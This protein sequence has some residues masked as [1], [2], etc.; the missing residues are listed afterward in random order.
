[1]TTYNINAKNINVTFNTKYGKVYGVKDVSINFLENE[2]TGIIGESGSGKSLLG[3]SILKLLSNEA[4]VT[5]E[6]YFANKD[7]ISLNK[8]QIKGIR[9]CKVGFIPQNPDLSLNPLLTI[10]RQLR[11]PLMTHLNMKKDESI[12]ICKDY[13]KKFGFEN[14][15]KIIKSYPF[16]L[17]GG[18][19]QRILSIIGIICNPK[20]LIADEPTKGLDSKLRKLV[21]ENLLNIKENYIPSMIVITHDL[22]F[23]A[24]LCDK[25][26]VM[27]KGQIVEMGSNFD[28]INNPKHPYTIGLMN[29]T[30]KNGM[31]PINRESCDENISDCNFYDRCN[32]RCE[33]CLKKINFNS[34]SDSKVRCSLYD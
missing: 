8:S 31:I 9:G 2:V 7:L 15:D 10:G 33:K 21:Y 13:L 16:Q 28:V 30:I 32:M 23:A 34:V 26:V 24:K 22:Y 11:E 18:M 17:S 3:M 25:I 12:K 14:P 5:G 20:Y 29:A 19:N 4:K 27:Y 6:C 1:M